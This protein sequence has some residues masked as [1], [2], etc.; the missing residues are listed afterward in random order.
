MILA[1]H[2]ELEFGSPKEPLMAEAALLY[3]LDY[4]DSR[5]AALTKYYNSTNKGEYTDQIFAFDKKSFYIPNID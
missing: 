5:L 1:H 3:Y 4:T 2:G